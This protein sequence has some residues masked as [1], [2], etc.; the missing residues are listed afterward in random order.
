MLHCVIPHCLVRYLVHQHNVV[1]CDAYSYCPDC[2]THE[3]QSAF[4][5]LCTAADKEKTTC[6]SCSPRLTFV[7][8]VAQKRMAIVHLNGCF[9]AG[10]HPIDIPGLMFNFCYDSW[11]DKYITVPSCLN[12]KTLPLLL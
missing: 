11:Y 10:L 7:H 2:I 12:C 8:S 9:G 6:I 5:I 1:I 4:A 3:L